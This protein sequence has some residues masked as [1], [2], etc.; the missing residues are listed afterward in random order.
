[1]FLQVIRG[2]VASEAD[3]ERSL[4][5]WLEEVA[6]H[7]VGWLGT[8]V[9]TTADGE[10]VVL[11][12]FTSAEDAARNGD[13]P[14]QQSWWAE[15]EK[16]FTAPPTFLD[17]ADPLLY[18]G[19]GTGRAGFVQVITGR[20]DDPE[21]LRAL[22]AR[23]GDALR[24]HRPDVLGATVAFADDGRV[25]EH[26]WFADESA[27]RE[28]E[29]ATPPPEVAEVMAALSSLDDLR[30]LDLRAP[31]LAS[32]ADVLPMPV[33]HGRAVEAFDRVVR[34]VGPDQWGLPTPCDEWDVRTLLAHVVAEDL[35]TPPLLE[36]RTI[37]EVGDRFEG[38]VLGEDPV[39]AW[40]AAS[41]AAVDAVGRPGAMEATTH[42][43]FG[44]LPGR[45]Y[46]AQLVV[47][48]IVHGWDLATAIGADD[49][50]DPVLLAACAD[51]FDA[52]EEMARQAGVIGPAVEPAT[53]ADEQAWLL[54]RFG[55]TA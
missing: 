3:A 5:R 4:R 24:A 46:T 10:H 7:A 31:L 11:A 32:P 14:L 44:D 19:G 38:D 53:D 1:M 16:V 42:L 21:G 26:V 47:D 22:M 48:H 50:I 15:A 20:T 41:A 40:A 54:G 6:P 23:S 45:A 12:R 27:A 51:L 49:R 9:G 34:A 17:C 39:G 13:L 43:S 30:F 33:L 25:V 28:R 2:P 8:T 55:R 29:A 36:G 52:D 18:R 35:W 37:A